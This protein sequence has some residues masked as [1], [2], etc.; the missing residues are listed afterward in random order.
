[1]GPVQQRLESFGDLL[2]LVVGQFGECSPHLHTLLARFA[3]EKVRKMSRSGG[4]ALGL[5]KQ[6]LILQQYRRRLSV[7][8]IRAQS[9]CLLSRLGHMSE[10]ARSAAQRRSQFISR[11]EASHRDLRSHWEAFVRGQGL[12]KAGLLHPN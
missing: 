3:D 10:C 7:C 4:I 11:E 5:D 2:C 1:M 6:S 8:A 12:H 9:S